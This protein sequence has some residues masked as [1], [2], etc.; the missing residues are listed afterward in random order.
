M[1]LF[2]WIASVDSDALLDALAEPLQQ[3]GLVIDPHVS[4]ASQVLASDR[5]NCGLPMAQR[6]TVLASWSC[7][8]SREA[9]LEVR[10]SEPQLRAGTRC[11]QIAEHLQAA[12]PGSAQFGSKS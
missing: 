1:A 6:V 9:Q 7:S 2:S 4:S 5:P 3:L 12:K 11:Q 8:R 10:S